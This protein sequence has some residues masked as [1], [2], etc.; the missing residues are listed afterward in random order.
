MTL[1]NLKLH[2]SF[3]TAGAELASIFS[4]EKQQEFLW[5]GN[6]EWWPRR[7]PVL[8]PIVGKLN[9]N[10]FRYNGEIYSLPQHGFARDNEFTVEKQSESATT[11]LL[12]STEVLLTKFPFDFQLRITYTL[13]D[14][15][16]ETQYEVRNPG[17]KSMYFSIGAW[18][19]N[20]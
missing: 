18:R 10:S 13:I 6:K 12:S 9:Q 5:Q 14:S 2:A 20:L 7:A 17:S 15:T 3:T 11:F 16:L 8:F 1:D 19:R 4:K